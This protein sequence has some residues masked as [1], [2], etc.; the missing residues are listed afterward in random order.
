MQDYI[1]SIDTALG[2]TQAGV[3]DSYI[4][5]SESKDYTLESVSIT[6]SKTFS[7]PATATKPDAYN[8]AI[9][10][11]LADISALYK[12]IDNVGYALGSMHALNMLAIDQVTS[13]V[14]TL[15]KLLTKIKAI[16]GAYASY[17]D[18]IYTNFTYD[19]GDQASLPSELPKL[20]IDTTAKGLVKPLA[21][22]ISRIISNAN[23]QMCTVTVSNMI[24]NSVE[25][26]HGLSEAIDGDTDTFW[27]EVVLDDSPIYLSPA[28]VSWLPESYSGGAA[29]E[30]KFEF[31]HLTQISEIHIKP[32]AD[33]PIEV[34]GMSYSTDDTQSKADGSNIGSFNGTF[35]DGTSGWTFSSNGNSITYAVTA[36]SND[37]TNC[38]DTL[39]ST[40]SYSFAD[41]YHQ[42][43][44]T[45]EVLYEVSFYA[46]AT[47]DSSAIILQLY[48]DDNTNLYWQDSIALTKNVWKKYTTRVTVP[49]NRVGADDGDAADI[50]NFHMLIN[51]IRKS[52]GVAGIVSVDN[53][54]I[55][56][57][58]LSSAVLYPQSNKR[59]IIVPVQDSYGRPIACKTLWLTLAQPNY[60]VRHYNIPKS[61]A[62]VDELYTADLESDS[63][64]SEATTEYRSKWRSYDARQIS[65]SDTISGS[66][67]IALLASKLGGK[68]KDLLI[69]LYRLAASTEETVDIVK[70]EYVLGAWEID[71]RY[72][73][74]G[75]TGYWLSSPLDV[76]GEVRQLTMVANVNSLDEDY[77][78]V[79]VLPREDSSI[80]PNDEN[81]L[82]KISE[83]G[84]NN[85]TVYFTAEGEAQKP[86]SNDTAN[87]M[88]VGVREKT[89]SSV[90][91]NRYGKVILDSYPYVNYEK[92]Y[93]LN[94]TLTSGDGNL[95]NSYDPN[96]I[97]PVYVASDSKLSV[98]S[99]YTPVQVTLT[100]S[101]QTVVPDVVGKSS[102]TKYTRITGEALTATSEN[103]TVT[104]LTE[105]TASDGTTSTAQTTRTV[106]SYKLNSPVCWISGVG[107]RI[108]LY[109]YSI[110]DKTKTII[111]SS[112][113]SLR[114]DKNVASTTNASYATMSRSINYADTLELTISDTTYTDTT[115][116]TLMADYYTETSARPSASNYD[117]AYDADETVSTIGVQA[118]PV[119]RNVTD[120]V[121][122]ATP[123]LRKGVF[124]RTDSSYYPVY[125]YYVDEY[126][127]VVFANDLFSYGDDP[128]TIEISYQTLDI[129]PRFLIEYSAPDTGTSSCYSP[130][131]TNYT[132]LINAR[133]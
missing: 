78:N 92:I 13:S 85:W 106:R 128:P 24:G 100:F 124:D 91:S 35:T 37:G 118:Y 43:T 105:S 115:K 6:G 40:S 96:A 125:E 42:V 53:I 66:S 1:S 36:E 97:S 83:A 17:T 55:N 63:S 94:S 61:L 103:V 101:D 47:V 79:Y 23:Q 28:T 14:D 45:D 114:W 76:T 89:V 117:T 48:D 7:V 67:S 60:N 9:V 108:S 8:Q 62:D 34:L 87:I 64:S 3:L 80:N 104:D 71:L 65:A 120:Y 11:A 27:R 122:G 30:L 5:A 20:Q 68:I 22:D 90:G 44:L 56:Q 58:G 4:S 57:V 113:V 99:G 132:V 95:Y 127:A 131:I 109:W 69:K 126:G 133:N 75:A 12:G 77:V 81:S 119:T 32:L 123:T 15:E 74:Y 102:Y 93:S 18:V 82:L 130:I 88:T 41:W 21:M 98:A 33:Y 54:Q 10:T 51:S 2:N 19:V 111:D 49:A 31:D 38:L 107:A 116:Y 73:D 129:N 59:T 25:T 46:K 112:Y 52:A 50:F 84:T 29:A 121:G 16:Y 72:K 70:Y 110:E 26:R 39:F 86:T